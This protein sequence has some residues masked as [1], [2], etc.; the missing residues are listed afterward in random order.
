[1]PLRGS[2]GFTL[3]RWTCWRTTRSPAGP[4]PGPGTPDESA[5]GRRQIRILFC[6]FTLGHP[7]LSLFYTENLFLSVLVNREEG[8]PSGTAEER[9]RRPRRR[10]PVVGAGEREGPADGLP[11]LKVDAEEDL[12][13]CSGGRFGHF[14]GM[15]RY[16]LVR[17][18]AFSG[19]YGGRFSS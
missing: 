9:R 16:G 13:G 1:M 6:D 17:E 11:K 3:T 4:P 2:H 19:K 12:S 15:S 14:R 7:L 5:A 8:E 18:N 10:E